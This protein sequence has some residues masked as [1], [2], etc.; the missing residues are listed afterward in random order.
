MKITKIILPIALCML[1]FAIISCSD[2]ELKKENEK[3]KTENDSLKQ[4]SLGT[5]N[6]SGLLS[7]DQIVSEIIDPTLATSLTACFRNSAANTTILVPTAWEFESAHL[8]ALA[9]SAPKVKF[10]AATKHTAGGDSLT[11][12]A[13]GV[14]E[15]NT[16]KLTKA[17]GTSAMYEFAQPCPTK[18]S[19]T[20]TVLNPGPNVFRKFKFTP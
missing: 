10:Y 16:D 1:V 12:I 5:K 17:D 7:P 18:C 15:S 2:G 20:N 6:L 13:V 8:S 11:L 19:N 4:L 3:L 9:V 14:D